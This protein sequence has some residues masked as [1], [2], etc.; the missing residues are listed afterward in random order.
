MSSFSSSSHGKR[1][2]FSAQGL[3]DLRISAS[4]GQTESQGAAILRFQE[5]DYILRN[6]SSLIH[7]CC[8]PEEDKPIQRSW[9]VP[10]TAIVFVRRFYL[11]NSMLDVDPRIITYALLKKNNL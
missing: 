7:Q 5:E 1:W 9:K 2:L 3:I 10:A 6:F 4:L 8:G 11:R